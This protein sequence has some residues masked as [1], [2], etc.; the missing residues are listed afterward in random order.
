MDLKI[1][2]EGQEYSA[3]ITEIMEK[4][5]AGMSTSYEM[6]LSVTLLNAKHAGITDAICQLFKDQI[7]HVSI[8]KIGKSD[9]FESKAKFVF[10][11]NLKFSSQESAYLVALR[12][13]LGIVDEASD[14]E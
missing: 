12:S 10:P 6:T 4:N 7:A 1:T 3:Q 11:L 9:A 13:L 8:S 14:E 2:D 5:V